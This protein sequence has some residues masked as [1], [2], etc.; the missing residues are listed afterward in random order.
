M[1][2]APPPGAPPGRPRGLPAAT[3]PVRPLPTVIA[4]TSAPVRSA[5]LAI[6]LSAAVAG[7]GGE[8][9]VPRER[10]SC[11]GLAFVPRGG[12][13]PFDGV[14]CRARRELL[15][16]RY[17]VTRALWRS[18]R[19]ASTEALPDLSGRL[20]V[21][22][23]GASLHL[24]ATGMTHPEAAAFASA[25][26]M[27]LPT[28]GE[29]M[30]LAAGSRAQF[31]PY[32]QN[33]EIAVANTAEIGLGRPAAAGTFPGGR[34]PTGIHD[35]LGNVWE[36]TDPPLPFD[37]DPV[38]WWL[39]EPPPW[40]LWVMGGSYLTPARPLYGIGLHGRRTF[41]ARGTDPRH[42]AVD[43]GLRCVAWAEPYLAA[44]AAEW[45][46]EGLRDRVRAVGS[47]WGPRAVP[48]L[49]RLAADPSAPA[50]LRWLLEGARR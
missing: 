44:H 12:N 36:W 41:H 4:H 35:L 2:A 34:T 33:R 31:F 14:R 9:G 21:V 15:V 32:G 46:R 24:P 18:V 37:V 25:R 1:V 40:G 29:W 45:S 6:A 42:R 43:V 16:D 49:E 39:R 48:L 28:V 13:E 22:W 10:L 5:V 50:A 38:T 11:E 47:S 3:D 23:D 20:G 8:A 26:G 7:C 17:E 19:A 27:R 30:F